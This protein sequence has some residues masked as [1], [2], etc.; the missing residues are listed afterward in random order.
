MSLLREFFPHQLYVNHLSTINGTHFTNREIDV[1]SCI[2]NGRKTGKIAFL[3]S[4]DKSTIQTH[5]RNIMLKL[6]CNTQE[7]IIDFIEASD[8]LPFLRR[9]YSLLQGKA[10]FE[11]SLK[12]I[13]KLTRKKGRVCILTSGKEKDSFVM[14]LSHNLSLAGFSVSREGECALVVLPETWDEETKSLLLRKAKQKARTVLVLLRERKNKAISDGLKGVSVIDFAKQE[15]DYFSFFRVLKKLLPTL[16]FDKVINDFKAKYVAI[17]IEPPVSQI[18]SDKKPLKNPPLPQARKSLMPVFLVA[19]LIICCFVVFHL[20]H[21]SGSD[22]TVR[23]DFILPKE[24]I[25]LHRPALMSHITDILKKQTGIQ[26]VAVVGSGGAGK[27]TLARH[28]AHH[29]KAP[30]IWEI[31]AE[32]PGVL[33]SSFFRLAQTLAKTEDNQKILRGIK[34]IKDVSERDEKILQF[35]KKNLKALSHWFLIYDNVEKFSD[36]QRYFPQDIDIWGQG[37]V[38]VT[39]RNGNIQH[40]SH[41]GGTLVIGELEPREKLALFSSIMNHDKVT[42]FTSHQTAEVK[43]FLEHIPSFPLDVSVAAYYIK[44]MNISYE[45]YLENLKNNTGEFDVVQKNLLKESGD[46]TKTRY[47]IVAL[48]VK[49]II[50]IHKDFRDLLMLLSLFDSQHIPREVLNTYTDRTVVDGFINQLKAYS[51]IADDKHTSRDSLSIHRS[52]QSICLHSLLQTINPAD[53]HKLLNLIIIALEK[54]TETYICTEDLSHL[55]ILIPHYEA[56]L[57]HNALLSLALRGRIK[58]ELGRIY[59]ALSNLPKAKK[60][61]DEALCDLKGH[62]NNTASF[63]ARSLSYS[64]ILSWEMGEFKTAEIHL[65]KSLNLY[66]KTTQKN[67]TRIVRALL[68]LGGIYGETDRE[69]EALKVIESSFAYLSADQYEAASVFEHLGV[70]H[71]YLGHYLKAEAS[72]KK[73]LAI[74]QQHNLNNSPKVA[75][76]FGRLG[77]L[78]RNY[79]FYEAAEG[80]HQ[81]SLAIYQKLYPNNSRLVA[82]ALRNLGSTCN[83]M[84]NFEKGREYLQKSVRTFTILLGENNMQTQWAYRELGKSY[85]GLGQLKKAKEIFEK[86]LIGYEK[87]FGNNTY[88][89]CSTVLLLG[90]L[91]LEEGNWQRGDELLQQGIKRLPEKQGGY[92]IYPILE[93]AAEIYE[94]KA[95]DA[96]QKKDRAQSAFFQQKAACYLEEALKNIRN[97]LPPSNSPSQT[98]VTNKLKKLQ[99]KWIDIK[100]Q[101]PPV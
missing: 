58:A 3:L 32:T 20:L 89:A 98:R 44:N 27:T 11:K 24:P 47:N 79:E 19:C 37:Q 8:K 88:I 42:S 7:S 36:I 15:N 5:V 95:F 96:S 92:Y 10:L 13:A 72:Y 23:S 34:E 41:I 93:K 70:I 38:I 69:K 81:R 75:S 43:K 9:Y 101:S 35:V 67:H 26:T 52:T 62:D 22:A 90:G 99:E 66:K 83:S 87:Y 60:L 65:K 53:M 85:L 28:Y 17:S 21:K 78:Y 39:T 2:L 77:T 12:E 51:L 64:G 55:K 84:G 14:Q 71:V 56:L 25:L 40:N 94:E 63:Y 16:N 59:G 74:C 46:Y 18:I 86:C 29:Q 31:N 54:N 73:G 33:H 68:I 6:S 100:Q 48:S 57:K 61:L 50:G 80:Y 82:W 45:T 97:Q 4:I 91:Y 76:I 1:I 49:Q 30:V